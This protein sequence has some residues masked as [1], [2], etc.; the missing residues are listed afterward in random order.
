MHA[1]ITTMVLIF[2]SIKQNEQKK[3]YKNILNIFFKSLPYDI[4]RFL[5]TLN[6]EPDFAYVIRST[7]YWK[8][9]TQLN[10]IESPHFILIKYIYIF[11]KIRLINQ[12]LIYNFIFY[13]SITKFETCVKIKIRDQLKIKVMV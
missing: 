4:F 12:F 10:I 2:F 1:K 7:F 13:E 11:T 8:L 3:I 9:L 6:E 5:L